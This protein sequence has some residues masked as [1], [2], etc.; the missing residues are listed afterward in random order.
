MTSLGRLRAGIDPL[1]AACLWGGM[2]VVSRAGFGL[3]PPVTLGALRVVIGGAALTLAL[4]LAAWRQ[5]EA[6]AAAMTQATTQATT[7]GVTP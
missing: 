7:Q 4:W 3:I 1:L 5:G 2:Y 6:P